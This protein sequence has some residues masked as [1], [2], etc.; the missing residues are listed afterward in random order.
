MIILIRWEEGR[1]EGEG[2]TCGH[3]FK[4]KKTFGELQLKL[5]QSGGKVQLGLLK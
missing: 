1:K 2:G 5:L 3:F 4:I